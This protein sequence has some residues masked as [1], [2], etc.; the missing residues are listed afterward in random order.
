M[1]IVFEKILIV[2]LGM[3]ITL[4]LGAPLLM[5]S[6]NFVA[7]SQ[8]ILEWEEFST[9]MNNLV[10]MVD[11]NQVDS[12]QQQ[13]TVPNSVL[14]KGINKDLIILYQQNDNIN[15]TCSYS[16]FLKVSGFNFGSSYMVHVY[17]VGAEWIYVNFLPI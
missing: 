6:I 13:L 10:T 14:V 4:S 9:N 11:L 12:I 15:K 8:G 2:A 3:M 17:R 1:E 5:Q 7:R 16:R